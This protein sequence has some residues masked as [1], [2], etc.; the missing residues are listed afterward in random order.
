MQDALPQSI[1]VPVHLVTVQMTTVLRHHSLDVRELAQEQLSMQRTINTGCCCWGV[2]DAA[3]C[4]D[5]LP[6]RCCDAAAAN[7]NVSTGLS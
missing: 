7:A 1:R 4:V 6:G 3:A 2:E 5:A